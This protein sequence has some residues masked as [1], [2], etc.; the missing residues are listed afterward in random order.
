MFQIFKDSRAIYGALKQA[1]NADTVYTMKSGLENSG[2]FRK[3]FAWGLIIGGIFMTITVLGAIFGIPM[4]ILGIY[5]LRQNKK[6][7]ANLE[8]AYQKRLAELSNG[9][10][11]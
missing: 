10:L 2:G 3:F 7:K 9:S 8:E 4:I 1:D 11:A 5:S 6:F